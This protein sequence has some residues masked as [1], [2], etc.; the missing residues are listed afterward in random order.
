MSVDMSMKI[1]SKISEGEFTRG[2]IY[3]VSPNLTGEHPEFEYQ[4]VA[5]NGN[6]HLLSGDFVDKNFLGLIE[7]K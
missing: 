3:K 7:T 2:N 6:V 1:I 5:D 4:T